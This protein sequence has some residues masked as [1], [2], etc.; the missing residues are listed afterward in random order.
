MTSGLSESEAFER[1]LDGPPWSW[2]V[3][4]GGCHREDE[5]RENRSEEL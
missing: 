2:E 1:N 5:E 3:K 4:A